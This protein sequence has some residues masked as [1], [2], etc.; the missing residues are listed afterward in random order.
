MHYSS[1]L[2]ETQKAVPNTRPG[3]R[4]CSKPTDYSIA[5]LAAVFNGGKGS[6]AVTQQ[7]ISENQK[8]GLE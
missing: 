6:A 7:G 8:N 1:S 5:F 3:G 2:K 4:V